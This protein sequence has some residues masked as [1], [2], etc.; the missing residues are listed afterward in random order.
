MSGYPEW[1][2]EDRLVEQ[3][4]IRIIQERFELFGFAPIETRSVERLNVILA[5]GETDKEIYTL[6]RLQASEHEGDKDIGLHFDLTVPFARYVIENRN[7]LLFPFRRYQIQK[8]WRGEKPGLGRYREFLQADFD[9]V[10]SRPLGVHSDIEIIQVT[11]DIFSILP[12]PKVQLLVNKRKLLEGFYRAIGIEK[13]TDVLRIIDKLDKIG[14]EKVLFYLVEDLSIPEKKAE[15]CLQFG[16]IK[17]SKV[18]ELR[19]S[20]HSFGL[21]H[22]LI[23]DGIEE[24]C[25]IL[26]DSSERETSS[27]VA[28]LSI[29]RGFD[30][31]TGT[32]CEVKFD[33]FPNYPTIAAGGR[34]DNL[35]SDG[36]TKLQ[37]IGMS[38][39]ITRILGTV[40][41]E[42]LLYS[43]RKVPSTVMIALV[44]EQS[45][46]QSNMIARKL[47]SRGIPCEVFPHAL[48]Y[49]K[50][51][52]YADGKGIPYVWFPD[53]S[54]EG[55]G[56]IRDLR[57]REQYPANP[58]TWS[59]QEKDMKVQIVKD[60]EAM[61]EILN[62]NNYTK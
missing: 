42:G 52:S 8:A 40:L 14:P 13:V 50:Q 35:V 26:D 59:P 31:Y 58:E 48:K 33:Q 29:A 10:D 25:A 47:R 27:I 28:D 46:K 2:P 30:Y 17:S 37:G 18:E 20:V 15:K 19:K 39:G 9:I 22:P 45:R 62:N 54:G 11:D 36:K 23:E 7:S 53:E 34:Y 57:I 49:G 51:I 4:I 6:R 56:E 61:N 21:V 43:D 55:N 60:D 1:L 5:K 3:N 16:K 24:L 38:I 12:I 32:V 44:S 41:H